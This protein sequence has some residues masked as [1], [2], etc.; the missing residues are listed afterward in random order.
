MAG[1]AERRR[2]FF[3]VPAGA[4]RARAL[5]RLL[6]DG[7][8]AARGVEVS[9]FAGELA[10]FRAHRRSSSSSALD[11]LL[12]RDEAAAF[13]RRHVSTIDRA[14]KAGELEASQP[15]GPGGAVRYRRR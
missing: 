14:R 9:P 2:V 12:T 5:G 15:A 11:E 10:H 3:S 13:A 7:E 4:G 8:L 1:T 6:S